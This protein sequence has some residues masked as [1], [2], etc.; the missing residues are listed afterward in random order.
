MVKL[1]LQ[2]FTHAIRISYSASCLNMNENLLKHPEQSWLISR[3]PYLKYT[4]HS[5]K[6]I[7]SSRIER[8]NPRHYVRLPP[9]K[10]RKS[11]LIGRDTCRILMLVQRHLSQ[12]K[13]KLKIKNLR[14]LLVQP[15]KERQEQI[16]Q[17]TQ[18]LSLS[19][20]RIPPQLTKSIASRTLS[21]FL[22]TIFLPFL[23]R[24]I[25]SM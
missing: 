8:I 21:C 14:P 1:N 18:W 7:I 2:N 12:M 11:K 23:E 25:I 17:I 5:Q 22:L 19:A 15:E 10:A 6:G 9:I 24:I 13:Q 16:T 4:L 20:R 3:S